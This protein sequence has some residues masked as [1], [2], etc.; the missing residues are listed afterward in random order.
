[1][2]ST[3]STLLKDSLETINHCIPPGLYPVLKRKYKR[4]KGLMCGNKPGPYPSDYTYCI[5][6]YKQIEKDLKRTPG[7]P[8]ALYSLLFCISTFQPTGYCQG[9]NYL[10]RYIYI[11]TG[12]N[13]S[14]TF[15]VF[16]TLIYSYN[17]KNYWSNGL[18]GVKEDMHELSLLIETRLP[19]LAKLMK[20][21]EIHV[22]M[23][24]VR[25][26]I[27]MFTADIQDVDC[28]DFVF[29]YVLNRRRK[30]LVHVAFVVCK[31]VND[32]II[33]GDLDIEDSLQVILES[34][35][36]KCKHLSIIHIQK[37]KVSTEELRLNSSLSS[38]SSSSR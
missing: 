23:F 36:T 26:F 2:Y 4:I 11:K 33:K 5:N 27:C 8:V 25:W 37:T 31:Q 34:F 28:L 18:S 7:C 30:A 12:N 16:D 21:H 10:I 38:S 17:F 3:Y 15:K 6:I 1:M 24:A 13:S 14:L 22:E 20:Q 19:C 29:L 32:M 9:M 35:Q